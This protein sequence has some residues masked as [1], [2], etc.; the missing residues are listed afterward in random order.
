MFKRIFKNP[1]TS[2][3]AVSLWILAIVGYFMGRAT[4]TEVGTFMAVT[5]LFLFAKDPKGKE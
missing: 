1:K 5:S 3:V 4:L 2:L